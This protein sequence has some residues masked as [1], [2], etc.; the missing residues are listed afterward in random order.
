MALPAE[1]RGDFYVEDEK[2]SFKDSDEKRFRRYKL[3]QFENSALKSFAHDTLNADSKEEF[4]QLFENI[5]LEDLSD[6]DLTDLFFVAGPNALSA[7]IKVT[8]ASADSFTIADQA[9]VYSE[10]RNAFYSAYST[11][12]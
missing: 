9:A 12:S 4:D 1:V 11:N 6:E 5:P 3:A 7:F 2:G 8:L 10:I